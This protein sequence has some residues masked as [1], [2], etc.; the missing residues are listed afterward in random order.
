[1]Y[2]CISLFPPRIRRLHVQSN[3]KADTSIT[4]HQHKKAYISQ[5][6]N[7]QAAQNTIYGSNAGKMH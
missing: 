2:V 1:M 4:L 3:T 5:K 6:V 7:S